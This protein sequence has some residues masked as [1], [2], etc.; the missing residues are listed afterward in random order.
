[1]YIS[2]F[3]DVPTVMITKSVFFFII[4][5]ICEHL[6]MAKYPLYK[7]SLCFSV[8]SCMGNLRF[9]YGTLACNRTCRSLS[10]PDLTCEVL[11]DPVEGCGCTSDSHLSN[12]LT[13]SPRSL[14]SCHHPGGVV[15]P[16]PV[17]IGGRQW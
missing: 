6:C 13:C 3:V 4:I 16:G 9:T 1:M 17:V 14:C 11:D 12:Q 2:C 7:L 10:G 15:P 8:P 5:I